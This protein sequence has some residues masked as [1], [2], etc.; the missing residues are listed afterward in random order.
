[1][2]PA[3]FFKYCTANTAKIVLTTQKVRWN[4]PLNFNDPFDCFFSLEPKFDLSQ[5]VQ[6]YQENF[7]DLLFQKEE[8]KLNPQNV[9]AEALLAMRHEAKSASREKLKQMLGF[10]FGGK[11]ESLDALCVNQREMWRKEIVNY[12]LFCVCE[13]NDNLLLWSHY[14][15]EHKG[16]AFQ[17]ECITELDVPLLVA[18]PVIYSDE[19]PGLATE[20][21]WLQEALGLRAPNTGADAW[22]RLVTTKAK[23]L[24]HE[25]EWRVVTTRRPYEN[26]GYEDATFYP[27]EISKVFLGCRMNNPDKAKIL[28]LLTND[29]AHVEVYQ[30]RQHPKKYQLEFERVK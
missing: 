15:D 5:F 1:M 27:Q 11:K 10:V 3:H 9:Y 16:A 26:E 21:E 2:H 23:A 22:P 24:E 7:L 18:K 6:K 25:K 19:A 13:K 14:A 12:R 28:S 17:F 30:A 29:F 8:P 4:S 20:E